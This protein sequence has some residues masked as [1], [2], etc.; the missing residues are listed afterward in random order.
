MRLTDNTFQKS[1]GGGVCVYLSVSLVAIIVVFV[2]TA[3]GRETP[4][5]DSIREK[6]LG[7]CVHPHLE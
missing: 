7:P 5:T 6:Y 1:G 4:E 3:E 2:I